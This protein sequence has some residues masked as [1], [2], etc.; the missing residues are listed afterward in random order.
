MVYTDR[1]EYYPSDKEDLAIVINTVTQNVSTY[2]IS[3]DQI[4]FLMQQNLQLFQTH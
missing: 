3:G 4:Q 2:N 1:I